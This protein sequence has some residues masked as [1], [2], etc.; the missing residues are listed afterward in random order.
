MTASHWSFYNKTPDEFTYERNPL[1]T[2]CIPCGRG[3]HYATGALNGGKAAAFLEM[4]ETCSKNIH[5]D[6]ENGIVALWHDESHL[7]KY[8]LD[9]N[10]PILPV[11][12]LYPE[13]WIRKKRKHPFKDD[14]KILMMEKEYP[15]WGGRD[16]LRGVTDVPQRG[17]S[18][19]LR[20]K[21]FFAE[22]KKRAD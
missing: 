21:K 2:A 9:K 1:S 19:L 10:P 3:R 12:Y 8:L 4:C 5:T 13:H 7:N 20:L 15:R 6:E 14:I 11:N 16:Y 18:P 17:K 22:R